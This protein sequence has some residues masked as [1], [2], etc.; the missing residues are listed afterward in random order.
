MQLWVA[1]ITTRHSTRQLQVARMSA[2]RPNS[3]K[4]VITTQQHCNSCLQALCYV[5]AHSASLKLVLSTSV[6]ILCRATRAETVPKHIEGPDSDS[7]KL[8][9]ELCCTPSQAAALA[10][11]CSVVSFCTSERHAPASGSDLALPAGQHVSVNRLQV[12]STT[13]YI[14]VLIAAS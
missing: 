3:A 6:G 9:S 4:T 14:R 12:F 7:S 13:A 2:S 10:S 5:Q 11:S 8:S 1:I